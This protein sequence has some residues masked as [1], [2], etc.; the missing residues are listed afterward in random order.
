[1][2]ALRGTRRFAYSGIALIILLLSGMI[3]TLA[4][5]AGAQTTAPCTDLRVG[6]FF[7]TPAQP[8][9]GQPS[10]INIRVDNVGTC[11]TP[12]F[13]V[14][15]RQD[16][17]ALTGPD[18]TVVPTLGAGAS[19]MVQFTFSFPTAGN[20][21]TIVELDTQNAVWET[22]EMN[23][24]EIRPVTVVPATRDL[25]V[26]NIS[27]SPPGTLANP[28]VQGVLAHITATVQNQG[29]APT[30]QFFV[31]VKPWLFGPD[32]TALVSN[33]GPGATTS[34]T[35][36]YT[37]PFAG[38]FT[39]DA[40]ADSTN[41]VNEGFFGEFNNSLQ[42]TIVVEPPLPD[43]EVTNA[44]F[45]PGSPVAGV[46]AHVDVTV[47]NTG[48]TPAG[49]SLLSWKPAWFVG[50]LLQWVDTL[51][52]G[53]SR[54]VGFDYTY[55]F[56]GTFDGVFTADAWGFVP[57][58]SETNNTRPQTVG[59]QTPFVDL[60]ITS[61][62]VVRDERITTVCDPQIGC[63]DTGT[64]GV[65]L[66]FRVTYQNLGNVAAGPFELEFNPGVPF[67]LITQGPAT[68]ST[69][70]Q[71][72]GA[73]AVG[74]F[75]FQ[76]AYPAS[77]NFRA[78][79]FIDSFGQIAESNEANNMAILNM[80]VAP[81]IDL[82]I[83]SFQVL[84]PQGFNDVFAQSEARAQITVKNNGFFEARNFLV[85]WNP[86]GPDA[87]L[88]NPSVLVPLLLPGQST[89]VT[90]SSSYLFPGDYTSGAMVDSLNFV[91]EFDETNNT[92]TT[93]VHVVPR[94]ATVQIHLQS[95]KLLNALDDGV[96]GEAEPVVAFG[97]FD[98]GETCTAFADFA[99]S[100]GGFLD[101][102]FGIDVDVANLSDF[103]CSFRE[104]S[105]DMDGDGPWT[106]GLDQTVTVVLTDPIPLIMGGAI[107]EEDDPLIGE[108][109]GVFFDVV[110]FNTVLT[111]PTRVVQR[112]DIDGVP[113]EFGFSDLTYK[114]TVISG[115]PPIFQP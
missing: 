95:V 78:V 96:N 48:N 99:D 41:A 50:D 2:A 1:M 33:L 55:P 106:L 111:A 87:G 30:G 32:L 65:P 8:V 102:L 98:P 10:T 19:R 86:A 49:G 37:F 109:G 94:A 66:T 47:T 89:T 28:L 27:T 83:T 45:T 92:A 5:P 31:R 84:P 18:P 46:A 36:D 110:D 76:Y 53:Q 9:Q 59:V 114:I 25:V 63:H 40:M 29:N 14:Q 81:G 17:F 42:Q 82:D 104:Y 6:Q 7:V 13:I 115:P 69:Q 105:I 97:A 70:V 11:P 57:E 4:G 44:V 112:A 60:T 52:V 71:G 77:G 26:T 93:S 54:T 103:D 38:T 100:I 80:E 34:R 16:R 43:L 90:I 20:F 79:G 39:V 12:A 68:L 75:D 35:F 62:E 74:H 67:E 22:N 24:L 85:S 101:D 72:L 21:L 108:V 15:W 64:Q 61:I 56:A 88:F 107:G 91:V 113:N 51:N 3:L 58:V 73:G 23:N